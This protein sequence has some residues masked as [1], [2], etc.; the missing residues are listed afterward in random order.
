MGNNDDFSMDKLLNNPDFD[1]ISKLFNDPNQDLDG[2]SF[3]PFETNDSGS[4]YS[5]NNFKCSYLDPIETCAYLNNDN[6]VS[7]MS[8][9]IQSISAKFNELKE[10]IDIFDSKNC[11]PDIILLQEI[12][13][14]PNANMFLLDNYHPLIYKCRSHSRGGGVGIYVKN[15]YKVSLNPHSIFWER[16]FETVIVDVSI[17]GKQFV[18][19]SLYRCITHPTL[20][21]RDQFSEFSELFANLVNNL[22]SHEL[23]LGGDLNLDVLKINTCPLVTSYID[24][25]FANGF[26][27]S[28]TKPTR[29]SPT[30]ATCIDHFLT[31]S[32]QNLYESIIVTSMLSDH[33]PVLFL[34]NL[35][36]KPAKITNTTFRDF[37]N[38][39]I[40]S[41]SNQLAT[42]DWRGVAGEG[43]PS[44]AFDNFAEIFGTIHKNFSLQKT[45]NLTKIF[46]KSTP[47]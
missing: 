26:I 13:N 14:I 28:I 32:S 36:K 40:A 34:K 17:N 44:A 30:S 47:G 25:L 29:C 3:N 46:T 24:M 18:I 20:S 41:F 33:F 8:I 35:F 9:N 4:P 16:I 27:Q 39:N 15:I 37:S 7:I 21:A 19:G 10:L 23:I 1:F 38:H 2:N 12:W 6:R 31:N 5:P 11:T 42:V 43:D 45:L 22:S